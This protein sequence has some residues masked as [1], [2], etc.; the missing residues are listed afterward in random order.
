[1]RISEAGQDFNLWICLRLF[2]F[3]VWRWILCAGVG[4]WILPEEEFLPVFALRGFLYLKSLA[5]VTEFGIVER[6]TWIT[7][8]APQFRP[9]ALHLGR[10]S[11]LRNLWY[12]S[13]LSPRFISFETM[14][15]KFVECNLLWHWHL[16]QKIL[17]T[18]VN[19]GRNLAL[20]SPHPPLS[21]IFWSLWLDVLF[22]TE[23]P[24]ICRTNYQLCKSRFR[25]PSFG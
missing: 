5:I 4:L 9:P 8:A 6:G 20:E 16:V 3:C 18:R 21:Y 22:H 13:Y 12:M 14:G 23:P 15:G 17:E 1:M 11:E 7:S 25:Y 2:S 19:F 10:R 24:N